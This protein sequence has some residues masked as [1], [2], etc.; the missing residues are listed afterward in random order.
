MVVDQVQDLV[1]SEFRAHG[2]VPQW[3]QTLRGYWI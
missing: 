3:Q 2:R 1:A